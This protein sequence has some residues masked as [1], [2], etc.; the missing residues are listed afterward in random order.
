[1][2]VD[3]WVEPADTERRKLWISKY[4]TSDEDSKDLKSDSSQSLSTVPCFGVAYAL[5]DTHAASPL[6][7][8]D[9]N[10]FHAVMTRLSGRSAEDVGGFN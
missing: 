8:L 2:K 3:I 1:M 10:G 7:K 5:V 4:S 6:L 9:R